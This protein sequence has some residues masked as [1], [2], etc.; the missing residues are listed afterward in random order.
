MKNENFEYGPVQ[1]ILLSKAN[2]FETSEATRLLTPR[3]HDK[4]S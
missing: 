4:Y 2:F 3:T 1:V